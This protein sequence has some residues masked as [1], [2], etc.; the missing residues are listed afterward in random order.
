[1]NDIDP[2]DGVIVFAH[3][4]RAIHPA[5]LEPPSVEQHAGPVVP[6][7]LDERACRLGSGSWA[8]DHDF[9]SC[10]WRS[11]HCAIDA[12]PRANRKAAGI[13]NSP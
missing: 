10:R 1:M 12:M 3:S 6:Y 7:D 2:R 5:L 13:R 9:P 4:P 8:A 11:C